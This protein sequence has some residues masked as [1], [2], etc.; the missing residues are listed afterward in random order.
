MNPDLSK[1]VGRAQRV[2]AERI[3]EYFQDFDTA[4][5]LARGAVKARPNW[6]N[7][8]TLDSVCSRL[9]RSE[10]AQT[11]FN[12][13]LERLTELTETNPDDGGAYLERA[14]LHRKLKHYPQAATDE[15]EVPSA[16]KD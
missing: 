11:A 10:E 14:E 8:N 15:E 16:T 3:A 9:G 13:A 7:L 5:L 2:S 4:L 6:D 12:R 1:N